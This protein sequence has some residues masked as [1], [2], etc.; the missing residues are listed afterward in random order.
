MKRTSRELKR[1]A[2]DILNNRYTI[3][4]GAFLTAGLIPTVIE[5]P[6]SLSTGEYPDTAQLIILGL[7]EFLILLIG[8]VLNVG[9]ARLHLNM[10]RG[11]SY[12]IRNIFDPFRSGAE[13]FF[14]AA[15][16]SGLPSLLFC[17]PAAF[18]INW[19]SRVDISAVSI[20]ILTLALLLSAIL[21]VVFLLN[22]SLVFFFLLDYPQMKVTAAFKE[23]RL[24]MKGNKKRLFYIL[25]SFLGWSLLVACSFFI[26]ALWVRPYMTQTLVTFY[27]DCTGELDRIP[28]RDY[29]RESSSSFNSLF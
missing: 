12:R 5:I 25:C 17:L 22:Y 20:A 15:L 18:G 27:L 4:M 2:R 14:G 28:V 1:I 13:R 11:E 16:L 8:L 19:F 29:H 9:V 6:F 10:T 7:A 24:L 21:L 23:S 26:A 3:P